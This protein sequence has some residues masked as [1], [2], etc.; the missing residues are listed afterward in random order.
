[1]PFWSG[2]ERTKYGELIR[3]VGNDERY[4]LYKEYDLI[5]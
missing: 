2:V 4:I 5:N 1:M 3:N